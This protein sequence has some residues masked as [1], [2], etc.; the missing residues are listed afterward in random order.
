MSWARTWA[1][2]GVGLAARLAVALWAAPRFP[3]AGD[4]FYYDTLARRL[5]S[6]SGYTWLWPDGAVTHAAH[7]P[8]GYPAL[9]A[10][11]YALFGARPLV[12][13][14]LNAL[15]GAAGVLAMH[16]LARAAALGWRAD[17]AALVL[18]LHPALLPYT[19]ALMTEGV[20]AALLVVAAA[21][22]SSA[23]TG[24][25]PW[26][27]WIATGAAIGV[28]TLVRPQCLL[29]A[30]VL[31]VLAARPP[32][33]LRALRPA[34]VVTAV[35][36]AVCAPW[37][38]RNCVKMHRCALVSVNGGWNLLIGEQS[39]TGGWS[40]VDVPASCREVWDEAAKDACFE[41]AARAQILEHP[42]AWLAKAP[43]KLASTFDYIGAAPWYMHLSN[44]RAFDDRDKVVHGAIETFVTRLL[45]LGALVASARLGGPRRRTRSA[46]AIVGAACALTLH[47]WIGYVALA[48][49]LGLLGARAL[50]RA[51]L[52]VP[53]TLAVIALTAATHAVFFGAGRYGLVVLPF[54]SALGPMFAA[55]ANPIPPDAI[56]SRKSSA[57]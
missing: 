42:F 49:A 4:G 5:A 24:G 25:R 11:G 7:Y 31:G 56:E 27:W 55:R 23:R 35:A 32:A 26:V 34:A 33:G 20:T 6:G 2:A 51:P 1:I 19:P 50:G 18:A 39:T 16:R 54:V 48:V 47:A 41:R 22:A 9:L 44:A 46:V 12:A 3:A 30:P 15:V 13:M 45:L 37:T 29:L 38:A 43:A 57:S 40:E 53:W 17:A 14:V 28:A 36:L 10:V 21:L 52:L 8:V